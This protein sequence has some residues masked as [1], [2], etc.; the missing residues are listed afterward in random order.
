MTFPGGGRGGGLP[1]GRSAG[2]G[3][4]VPRGSGLDPAPPAAV[5][6]RPA[7]LVAAGGPLVMHVVLRLALLGGAVSLSAGARAGAVPSPPLAGGERGLVLVADGAGDFSAA[8][9]AFRRE[10]DAAG[11]PLAVVKF[12]W[13]HGLGRILADHT[14]FAGAR[15]QGRRLAAQVVAARQASPSRDVYLV[16]HSDGCTVVLAAA[17][18]L[19]PATVER[20]VLLSPSVSAGYDVR[21]ALRCVRG[22]LDVFHSLRDRGYLGAAMALAGTADRRWPAR[23]AG[24]VG[25]RRLGVGPADAALYAKLFQH[26]WSPADAWTGNRG[27][28]YGGYQPGYLRNFVL[29]LLAP[30]GPA[31]AAVAGPGGGLLAAPVVRRGAPGPLRPSR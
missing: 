10:I 28:H 12:D 23:T 19:P 2:R 13:S 21:P 22:G 31:G 24:V 6:S 4:A 11:L 7:C 15:R 20:I 29:P 9:S 27:G 25:F 14:D 8:S 3:N 1:E 30:A 17:E 16:G 26:S 18:S 5:C